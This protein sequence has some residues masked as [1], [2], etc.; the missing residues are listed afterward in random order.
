[1]KT[2]FRGILLSLAVATGL[3]YSA[4]ATIYT[5]GAG[6]LITAASS[7]FPTG[8]TTLATATSPFSASGVIS[9]TL[10]STVISG[11]TSNPFANGLTFTYLLSINA[12]SPDSSSEMTVSSFA[13]FQTEISYNKSGSEVAPNQFSRD[14]GSGDTVRFHWL[15]PTIAAGQTGALVVVQT[16]ATA[17]HPTLAGIID[18][19][20]VNVA[21]L[22]P[23]AVPEP[24]TFGLVFVG[25][26]ATALARR[27]SVRRK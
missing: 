14:S 17:W 22:A 4:Q 6:G 25:L 3:V 23:I 1:M 21:S 15:I 24:S 16:D 8:G 26:A 18:G 11:D 10:I 7:G 2:N 13:N 9:G 5:L 19:L 27:Q 12:S 20:T